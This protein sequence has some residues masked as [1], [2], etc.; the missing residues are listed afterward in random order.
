LR[1]PWGMSLVMRP[2]IASIEGLVGALL[3]GY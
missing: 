1:V 2:T 3:E